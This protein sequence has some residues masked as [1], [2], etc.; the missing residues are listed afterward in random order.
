MAQSEPNVR[1]QEKLKNKGEHVMRK[2]A[3]HKLPRRHND[4]YVTRKSSYQS[5]LSRCEKL[6]DS[7]EPEIFIHG[8][9]AAVSSGILLALELKNKYFETIEVS[10]KT[11]TVDLVDD[12]E[13]VT[14]Q[15]DYETQTRQNSSVHIRVYRTALTG[16]QK[17]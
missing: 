11:S 7:G 2:R 16:L 15:A 5:Q 12:L 17:E 8:L 10:V 9:G 1:T 6:L 3:P 4:V 14:D 13:P